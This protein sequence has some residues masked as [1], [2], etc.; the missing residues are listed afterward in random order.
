MQ[1]TEDHNHRKMSV[2][3]YTESIAKLLS[4]SQSLYT[5]VNTQQ[6]K[7]WVPLT[8]DEHLID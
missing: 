2:V 7:Y 8:S 3:Q 6:T 4:F 5:S 1:G